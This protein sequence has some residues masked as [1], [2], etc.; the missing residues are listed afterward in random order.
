MERS[1]FWGI[2]P[3]LI[4]LF[5]ILAVVS[6]LVFAR[7]T[8]SR[9]K[10]WS[11]GLAEA[12]ELPDN[13][14]VLGLARLSLSTLITSGCL[15]ARRSFRISSFRAVVLLAIKWSFIAFLAGCALTLLNFDVM[16]EGLL[17]GGA[18][19][20][21]KAALNLAGML[22]TAGVLYAIAR[23]LLFRNLPSGGYDYFLL[24]L[25]LAIAVTPFVM[26]GLRFTMD[27]WPDAPYSPLG[28]LFARMFAG[29]EAETAIAAYNW[30]WALHAGLALFFV[31]YIPYSRIFHI[32]AA[33]ITTAAAGKREK[34]AG[35]A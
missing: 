12:G 25:L 10:A 11:G 32:F 4:E 19:V 6:L 21:F 23:R 24:F 2:N 26:Q 5:R 20:A 35:I 16:D 28:L 14:S 18:F 29:L 22:F 9:L 31:A 27:D 30:F 15:L 7:G 34:V 3:W 17:R 33:Q 8:Y 1:E 13:L